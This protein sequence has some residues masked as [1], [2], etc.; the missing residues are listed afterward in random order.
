MTKKVTTGLF[1]VPFNSSTVENLRLDGKTEI[2]TILEIPVLEMTRGERE[3]ITNAIKA[4]L[5][6]FGKMEMYLIFEEIETLARNNLVS[7][8]MKEYIP[9]LDGDTVSPTRTSYRDV[10]AHE[11]DEEDSEE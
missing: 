9:P 1:S 7:R 11:M 5:P 8:Y 10:F 6:N 2:H 4:V 3:L